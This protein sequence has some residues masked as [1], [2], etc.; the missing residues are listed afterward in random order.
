MEYQEYFDMGI[1]LAF[2]SAQMNPIVQQGI[3]QNRTS[4]MAGGNRYAKGWSPNVP[5]SPS[6]NAM[7]SSTTGVGGPPKLP[8]INYSAAAGAKNPAAAQIGQQ[9]SWTRGGRT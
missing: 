2:A 9:G 5:L 8:P 4:A 6:A 1:K 7:A 3:Q